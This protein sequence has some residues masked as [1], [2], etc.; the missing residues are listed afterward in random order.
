MTGG[1]C[2]SAAMC[3]VGQKEG[4]D[5]F[6]FRG[7]ESRV[8]FSSNARVILESIAQETNTPFV[9]VPGGYGTAPAIALAKKCEPGKEYYFCAGK[10]A[11]IIKADISGKYKY[12]ELQSGL[13]NGWNSVPTGVT[14]AVDLDGLFGWR[15]GCDPSE[16]DVPVMLDIQGMYGSKL[17]H[18]SLGYINTNEADQ[19]K[20]D[21]GFAK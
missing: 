5:V 8:L 20:G 2:A 11:A 17:F 14:G 10:H 19:V 16:P 13:K 12:L 6:D 4:Y 21:E 3:Y 18:R 15:F 1:S 9:T 7:G